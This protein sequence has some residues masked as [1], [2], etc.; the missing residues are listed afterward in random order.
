[1]RTAIAGVM[2]AFW[3][4]MALAPSAT[5]QTLEEARQLFDE[6][7][8]LEAATMGEQL[9]TSDSL[10]LAAEACGI[11]GRYLAP[12][13]ESKAIYQRG[14]ADAAKAIE[15][16][17]DNTYAHVQSAHTMGRYSQEIGV[18]AALNQGYAGRVREALDNALEREPDNVTAHVSLAAWH[19]EIVYAAGVIMGKVLYGA[20]KTDAM[21]YYERALELGPELNFVHA[22]TAAGLLLMNRDRNRDRAIREFEIAIKLPADT[23]LAR[24]VRDRAAADLAELRDE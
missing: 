17:P 10:A 22:E 11:Y 1:M 16:D 13:G 18:L 6:G 2:G 12:S 4:T 24:L 9:G 23:A 5:A 19:A 15:L 3:V 20:N 8:F 21:K 7:K 14:E